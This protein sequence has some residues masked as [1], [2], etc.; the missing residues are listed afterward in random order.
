MG[1]L[2]YL[3]LGF[4]LA[5]IAFNLLDMAYGEEYTV[6]ITLQLTTPTL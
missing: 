4:V 6:E 3:T 5:V 2:F 1:K